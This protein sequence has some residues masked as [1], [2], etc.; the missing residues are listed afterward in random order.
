MAPGAWSSGVAE[1]EP[2]RSCRAYVTDGTAAGT[3]LLEPQSA[4]IRW[5]RAL[6]RLAGAGLYRN[7]FRRGS[8]PQ[9]RVDRRHGRRHPARNRLAPD[10]PTLL[11]ATPAKLFYQA[12]GS[13]FALGASGRH[14]ELMGR[15]ESY[16]EAI[17]VA[18]NRLFFNHGSIGQSIPPS[19][20]LQSRRDQRRGRRHFDEGTAGPGPA[21]LISAA[22]STSAGATASTS[23]CGL[24]APSK[25]PAS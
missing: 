14:L 5:R 17:G 11:A 10:R 13:L 9:D 4:E 23:D 20:E 15:Y 24:G 12:G 8:P 22:T 3:G 7:R 6:L 1:E 2:A 18:G 25:A 19:P 16:Y 21:A